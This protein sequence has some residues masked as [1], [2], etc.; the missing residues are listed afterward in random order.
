MKY[1]I[2]VNKNCFAQFICLALFQIEWVDALL[3]KGNGFDYL[4]V[5]SKNHEIVS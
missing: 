3:I 4:L 5:F 2:D 1:D